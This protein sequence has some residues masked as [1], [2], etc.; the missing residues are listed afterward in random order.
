MVI[1]FFLFLDV[2]LYCSLVT[3]TCVDNIF[4]QFALKFIDILTLKDNFLGHNNHGQQL[5]S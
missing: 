3:K 4:S 1:I 5:L 2:K